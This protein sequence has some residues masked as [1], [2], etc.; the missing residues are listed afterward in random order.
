MLDEQ[1]IPR[2]LKLGGITGVTR[3]KRFH[4]FGIGQSRADNMLADMEVFK[5]GGDIKLGFPA[6]YP[7]LETKLAVRGDNEA[8]LL[9]RLAPVA[10]E[11]RKRLGN[12]IIAEDDQTLEG[13]ILATLLERGDTLSTAEMFSGGHLAARLAPLVGAE[14]AFRRG[15]VAR[16]PGELGINGVSTRSGQIGGPQ[17]PEGKRRQPCTG[18]ADRTRR[19]RR[20]SR[21]RRHDLC[22]HRRQQR[23]DLAPGAP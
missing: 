14:R 22:R 13:V 20:P 9:A 3:L 10:A 4:S 15:I 8:D 2:L 12:F 1:V 17:S 16:D 5:N 21:L 11:V 6:H 19:R 23:H 18:P 7:Q